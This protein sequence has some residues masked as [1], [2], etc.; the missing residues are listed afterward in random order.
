MV[1]LET[2]LRRSPELD[3]KSFEEIFNGRSHRTSV[4]FVLVHVNIGGSVELK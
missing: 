1:I 2:L 3:A 4:F